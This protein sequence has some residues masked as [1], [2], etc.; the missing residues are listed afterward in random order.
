MNDHAQPKMRQAAYAILAANDRGGYTV[1]TDR[2][3]PF[4]WNW[5][6]AFVAMGLSMPDLPA[7]PWGSDPTTASIGFKNGKPAGSA[8][9]LT[10]SAGQFVR[11]MLEAAVLPR[12]TVATSCKWTGLGAA[13]VAAGAV[14]TGWPGCA[15]GAVAPGTVAPL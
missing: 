10:W 15:P 6:S 12:S 1:P 7:S 14:A 2:L 9:A 13:G 3:Y 4:Q 5:D 11:L 8:S